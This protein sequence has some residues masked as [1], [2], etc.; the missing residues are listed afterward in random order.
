MDPSA[1]MVSQARSSTP[2]SLNITFKEGSAEDLSGIADISLDMVVSGQAAHW[3]D[4]SRAWPELK[5]KKE[6]KEEAR[7][8]G[9]LAFW[10]YR[11]NLLV[12][13]PAA[14]EI[15]GHYCYGPDSMVPFWEQPGRNTLRDRYRAIVPPS[16]DWQNL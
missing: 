14:T 11:D 2:S 7:S 9:T 10:E 6:E 12:G 8:G 1:V 15:F 3:F 16:E 5:I 13:Y 4:Y